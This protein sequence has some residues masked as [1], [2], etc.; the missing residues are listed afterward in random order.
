MKLVSS[1]LL[2]WNE[3][4]I[5]SQVFALKM[6]VN[7]LLNS[8][9]NLSYS[10]IFHADLF[11]RLFTASHFSEF[12]GASIIIVFILSSSSFR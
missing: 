2:I 7:S 12:S 10:I 8:H 3:K 5:S 6:A 9:K 1:S 4:Q 11:K